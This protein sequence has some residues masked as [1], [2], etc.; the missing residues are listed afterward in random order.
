[1]SATL[2]RSLLLIAMAVMLSSCAQTSPVPDQTFYRLPPP[3]ALPKSAS[4]VFPLTIVVG[5][6]AADGLYADRALIYALEPE[7][8]E[9]RQ[10]HYQLWTDPPTRLL[11]R[12]LVGVLRDAELAPLV[13][14]ALPASQPAVRISGA[15]LRFERVPTADGG[16]IASVAL[17]LRADQPDGTP[18]IDEIYRADALAEGRAL[19]ASTDAIGAAIDQ[20]FAEFHADL[21]AQRESNDA[22]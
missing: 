9:L 19:G 6:F 20:V 7:A 15:I 14:D 17:K 16:Q 18:M 2:A 12:R 11:Q 21:V 3:K 4:E 8:R 22:R 1:M 5:T 10:Y 13:I